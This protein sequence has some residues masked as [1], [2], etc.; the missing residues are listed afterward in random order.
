MA[1]SWYYHLVMVGMICASI[2]K[3]IGCTDE[4]KRLYVFGDSLFD[5]G[6]NQYIKNASHAPATYWPYGISN[7]NKSTG[8][9]CDGLIVP[10]YIAMKAK[11]PLLPP[12]LKPGAT[13]TNGVN[14]ASA[15]SGVL[16]SK[17]EV[18]NLKAQLENFKKVIELLKKEVGSEEE[19]K[20]VLMRSVFLQSHGGNDYFTFN[21]ASPNATQQQ[22]RQYV[23]MVV[24]NL[25]NGLQEMYNLG[26]R[27]LAIQNVGPLGCYPVTK[28]MHPELKGSCVQSFLT[29]AYMHNRLL[30][31]K[32][33]EMQPKLPGFSYTIFDYYTALDD[34]IKN[35]TKYG[36]KVGDKA[37]C[38]N[39]T[40]NERNC[41]EIKNYFLCKNPNE[42]V[43]FDGGHHTQK[44]NEQ[45]A[46]IL[47]SGKPNATAP[48]PM[49]H[50]FELP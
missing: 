47:W 50:L 15:G 5:A 8:R 35:P 36:F 20:K 28:A 43:L 3:P 6:N 46:E 4:K 26:M 17:M 37:C 9:L 45:F 42:Y 49:K 21:T 22:M 19:A 48:V 1:I 2:V 34:R 11:L 27:K 41:G 24:G 23:H 25:T 18:I 38:G 14:F 39:G 16:E 32:L 31:D 13:F 7:H 10:D 33:K 30:S 44:T 29:S 40:Y 12:Y